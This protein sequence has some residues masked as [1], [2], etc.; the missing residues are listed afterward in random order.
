MNGSGKSTLVKSLAI[1]MAAHGYLIR[2]IDPKGEGLALPT[3]LISDEAL[4]ERSA[5][6]TEGVP[7][8]ALTVLRRG[9]DAW[10][11]VRVAD[12]NHLSVT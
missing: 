9:V 2:H 12:R 4:S 6:L 11:V 10:V 8:C 1:R 3:N 5:H 7:N